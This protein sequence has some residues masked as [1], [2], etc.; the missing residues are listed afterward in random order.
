M[1]SSLDLEP[2]T[3]LVGDG[4]TDAEVKPVVDAFGA[5]TG[6]VRREKILALADFEITSFSQLFEHITA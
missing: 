4:M 1:I 2:P 6:A 5:F 3:L